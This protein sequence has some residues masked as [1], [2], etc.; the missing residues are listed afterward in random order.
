MYALTRSLS[1][2]MTRVMVHVLTH[3][4]YHTRTTTH[5][6]RI[7]RWQG[8]SEAVGMGLVGVNDCFF[9][10]KVNGLYNIL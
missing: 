2:V 6:D 4:Y 5:M 9:H 3:T 7:F 8:M 10:T 1:R